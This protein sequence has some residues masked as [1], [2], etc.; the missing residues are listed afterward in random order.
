M[1]MTTKDSSKS[2]KKRKMWCCHYCFLNWYYHSGFGCASVSFGHR[3]GVGV[4]FL[5]M[6][7]GCIIPYG[8]GVDDSLIFG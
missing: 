1:M 2:A 8:D 3:V 7:F 4:C 5:I 6:L